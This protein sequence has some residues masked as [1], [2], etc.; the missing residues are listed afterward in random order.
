MYE[1]NLKE[2]ILM[3]EQVVQN[4]DQMPKDFLIVTLQSYVQMLKLDS[5][6]DTL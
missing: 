1:Q 2:T 3:L 5:G 6:L 4:A